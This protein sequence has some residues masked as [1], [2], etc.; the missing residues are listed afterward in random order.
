MLALVAD[1]SGRDG[2]I[3]LAIGD[4]HSACKLIEIRPLTGGAFSAQLI[5][6][7]GALLSNHGFAKNNLDGFIVVDGPGSFTGLRVGLAAI[8]ALAEVLLKP[9]AVVSLLEALAQSGGIT[10]KVTSALDAGRGQIYI[11]RYKVSVDLP[12]RISEGI[13]TMDEFTRTISGDSV[14]TSD[15]RIASLAEAANAEVH[16]ASAPGLNLIAPLGW[17]KILASQTVLPE[18]LE[19]NYIARVNAEVAHPRRI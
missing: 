5:P 7:I 6:R 4:P 12:K 18:N 19:A 9:I 13:S 10:G 14:I 15:T 17:R 11:G 16:L 8:K 2:S 1:T 3:A